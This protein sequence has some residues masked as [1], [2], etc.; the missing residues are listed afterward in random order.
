MTRNSI[1]ISIPKPCH[2]SWDRMDATAQGAFCH[3][4]RKE[5]IDFS[6][7]TDREVVEYL[8]KHQTGCGRLR[9]DQLDTMIS[10]PRVDNGI[11]KW[12]ALFLGILPFVGLKSAMAF[13]NYKVVSTDQNA[14]PKK[15]EK[16]DT[17]PAV[18]ASTDS[19]IKIS[20]RITDE[21]NEGMINASIALLDSAGRPTGI[22]ILTDFDGNYS[23]SLQR[24]RLSK[25]LTLKISYI[26]YDTEII[27]GI[28][29]DCSHVINAKLKLNS[30]S[31][32]TVGIMIY[33]RQTPAQKIKYAFRHLFHIKSHHK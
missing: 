30:T 24:E 18:P 21:K 27:K 29:S 14:I 10:I 20:G 4:C 6:A 11:F 23:L 8:A 2:E 15:A 3:S 12:K 7:M 31:Y 26:G 17:A 16:K 13:P 25:D 32:T 22:G 5:V 1:H 19:T 28:S 9:K 33:T